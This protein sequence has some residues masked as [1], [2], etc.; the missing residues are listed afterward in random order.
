MET[1][2]IAGL[3]DLCRD[4]GLSVTGRKADLWQ[5]LVH[6]NIV[7]GALLAFKP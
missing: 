4:S 2:T 3:K 6:A 5:R 1:Y 7:S